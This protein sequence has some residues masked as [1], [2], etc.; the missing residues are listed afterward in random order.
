MFT[1]SIPMMAGL[2]VSTNDSTDPYIICVQLLLCVLFSWVRGSINVFVLLERCMPTC[3]LRSY[4]IHF[5]CDLCTLNELTCLGNYIIPHNY[6][7]VI[8]LFAVHI[9]T[10]ITTARLCIYHIQIMT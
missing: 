8:P 3:T 6:V 9:M 7:H 2:S 10:C 4:R 5:A 1:T